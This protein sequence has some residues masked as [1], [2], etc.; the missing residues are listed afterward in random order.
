[1]VGGQPSRTV[2]LVLDLDPDLGS[3]IGQEDWETARQA[4][5][6]EVVRLR[7]GVWESP[8]AARRNDL[9]GLVIIEGT[10]CRELALHDRN[11]FE[12]LGPGDVVQLP[13]VGRRSRLGGDVRLTAAAGTTLVVLGRS[14]ILAAARWSCLMAMVHRRLE[15]QRERL[16]V[17]G[18]IAHLPRAEH[19][20]LL[21]LWHLAEQWGR[22]T[23]KGTELPLVITHDL[24]GELTRSR[25]PTVTLAVSALE[26]EGLIRRFEDGSWLLTAGAERAVDAITTTGNARRPPLGESFMLRQLIC[27]TSAETAALCGEA[28]QILAHRA[29]SQRRAPANEDPRRR[30]NQTDRVEASADRAASAAR[31]A[32][33]AEARAAQAEAR[34]A[35]AH[36]RA[37]EAYEESA[38]MHDHAAKAAVNRGEDA[39]AARYREFAVLAREAAKRVRRV[40][41]DGASQP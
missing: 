26:S 12:V 17:Q 1:V 30:G 11:M 18:L 15:E 10:L 31:A 5:R 4:C 2:S 40:S 33:A 36:A 14:F 16:A 34:V 22:V 41:A 25:R 39:D 37:A 20:V 19:R 13:T 28:R 21:A 3:G 32:H 29:R 35:D 38:R 9:V 27:E 8:A 7:R 24:L 23:P 6:G